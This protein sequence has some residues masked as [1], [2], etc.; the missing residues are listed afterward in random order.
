MAQF[1]SPYTNRRSDSYGQDRGLFALQTLERVRSKVGGAFLV[2]YRISGEEFIPGGIT[3][4]E[5][6]TF[7]KRLA[8]Q[9][10][11]YLH[12][13][14]GMIE[15]AQHFVIPMYFPKGHLLS[16]AEGIKAEVTIPVIAVG[17]VHD[18][19]L[20]EQGCKITRRI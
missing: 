8:G 6:R 20:A 10:I 13:S 7:A 5:T 9:G 3:L 2:G 1:L 19:N 14:G 18:L 17:A 15:T 16:L 12:V 11:D 4:N